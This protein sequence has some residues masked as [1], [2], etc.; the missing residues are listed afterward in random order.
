[1]IGALRNLATALTGQQRF[2][3]G[4][5]LGFQDMLD[6]VGFA[7]DLA[8]GDVGMRDQIQLPQAMF[9]RSSLRF[10]AALLGQLNLSPSR[11]TSSA[12]LGRRSLCLASPRPTSF[13]EA[14][15]QT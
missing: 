4:N 11:V 13:R 12:G 9:P 6:A 14:T 3:F 5:D 2:E 15:R 10:D 7:I 1:M 8:A